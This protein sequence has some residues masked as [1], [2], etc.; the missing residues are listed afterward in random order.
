MFEW[1]FGKKVPPRKIEVTHRATPSAN[2]TRP[3]KGSAQIEI[4][5]EGQGWLSIPATGFYGS[6][7]RSPNGRFRIAWRDGGADRGNGHYVL[8]YDEEIVCK[9]EMER[10]QD[11]KVADNGVFILND[12]RSPSNLS[13]TFRAFQMDGSEFLTQDY[14][15]NLFTN[16]LSSDGSLAACQT[17]NSDDEDDSAILTVFDLAES[18]E[19]YRFRAE[20]GWPNTYTFSADGEVLTLGYANGEGE[21]AYK[22][23]GTFI[24]RDAWIAAR[25]GQGDLYMIRRVIDETGGKPDPKIGEQLLAAVDQGLVHNSWRDDRSQALGFRLR[26]EVLESMGELE[27]ALESYNKALA[28]NSKIGVKR[29]IDQ[30]R[31][32]ALAPPKR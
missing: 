1:L 2:T 23:D 3:R 28:L 6:Y 25:L 27:H 12:C 11:G 18:K 5:D 20:S 4:R 32:T 14:A 13:G 26:G 19:L 31:K 16:G 15:A 9:G 29:R 10:P 7:S 30:L 22:L 8:I 17:C 21:F 24:D